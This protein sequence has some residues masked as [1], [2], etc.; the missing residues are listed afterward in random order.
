MDFAFTEE[1]E[2]IRALAAEILGAEMTAERLK[3]AEREP[4]WIDA[5]LWRKLAEANLLGVAIPEAHGGMGMGFLALC[6]LLEEV[7]RAVAPGPW[8]ATLVHGALPLAAFGSDAQQAAWLPRVAAGTAQLAAA[9][10]DADSAPGA[11]PAT[12]ARRA[13]G[14]FVL[15]GRKRAV[16]GAGGADRVLVPASDERGTAVFLVDPRAAGVSLEAN[17]TSAGEPLFDVTLRG[18][19]AAE[20]DRLPADG[21]EVLRWLA[22]RALTAVAALQAGVSARALRITADY[23]KERVQFGVPIGSFQAVQ[24]RAADG[25]IDLE[26]MRWTLWQAA[27]RLAEGLPAERDAAVAKLWAADGGSRIANASLHLHGGLGSDVDYPI[28]RYFLWSKALELHGGGASPTLAR[29]GAELART[30]PGEIR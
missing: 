5:A 11:P 26:A 1:Q 17:L 13:G 24:H 30:G 12:R 9:L 8:L 25:F 4:G 21:A 22:P 20:A 16:A 3:A 19:R 7:G 2:A 29:L 28:H 23:V 10:D 6:V 27:W 18:V 15:D 14:G